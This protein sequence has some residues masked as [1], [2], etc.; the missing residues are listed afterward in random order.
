MYPNVFFLYTGYSSDSDQAI[1]H[2]CAGSEHLSRMDILATPRMS[3]HKL[4]NAALL[5][6]R[7]D[8]E[9]SKERSSVPEKES[10][11]KNQT[12]Q[13]KLKDPR[14]NRT[15]KKVETEFEKEGSLIYE[16]SSE[17]SLCDLANKSSSLKSIEMKDS[18]ESEPLDLKDYKATESDMS[19]DSLECL[20]IEPSKYEARKKKKKKPPRSEETRSQADKKSKPS[21]ASIVPPLVFPSDLYDWSSSDLSDTKCNAEQQNELSGNTKSETSN[22]NLEALSQNELLRVMKESSQEIVQNI[23]SSAIK[24]CE[25]GIPTGTL[26]GPYSGKIT[27]GFSC[28]SLNNDSLYSKDENIEEV[29]SEKTTINLTDI[30]HAKST[31]FSAISKR[32]VISM[33][34][35]TEHIAQEPGTVKNAQCSN[36]VK[37]GPTCTPRS[38][39]T[40]P[41]ESNFNKDIVSSKEHLDRTTEQHAMGEKDINSRKHNDFPVKL[42]D[43]HDN[44][45]KQI[46]HSMSRAL[47]MKSKLVTPSGSHVLVSPS[48]S[49][50]LVSS[51]VAASRSHVMVTHDSCTHASEQYSIHKDLM[52]RNPA[53]LEKPIA[54]Q[55]ELPSSLQQ[56]SA[57]DGKEI[58]LG[59]QKDLL[60]N[61]VLSSSANV[62]DQDTLIEEFCKKLPYSSKEISSKINSSS[63]QIP[64]SGYCFFVIGPDENV[65]QKQNK[66][67]PESAD[68]K[69]GAMHAVESVQRRRKTSLY[70]RSLSHQNE[71]KKWQTTTDMIAKV[72]HRSLSVEG[73]SKAARASKCASCPVLS[74]VGIFHLLR[75]LQSRQNKNLLKRFCKRSQTLRNNC[76]KVVT[77]LLHSRKYVL[78]GNLH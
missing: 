20:D 43:S 37:Q 35:G 19:V 25:R 3:R 72:H 36:E 76:E 44:I 31:S 60:G 73:K 64:T 24:K 14:K 59:S 10:K 32:E 7:K 75:V 17:S 78:E 67:N 9:A 69:D 65:E 61:D 1:R 45:T 47:N 51:D 53:R 16:G 38:T 11:A 12:I 18:E 34:S 6:N 63:D 29:C 33:A 55:I 77:H 8:R 70:R 26:L 62:D 50:A 23:M 49:Q 52:S 46:I 66:I 68:K 21:K 15:V 4:K 40:S 30:S 22:L 74:E 13:L 39:Q 27:G 48:R 57:Q 54:F 56:Y 5:R 28:E 41:V 58:S 2:P 42:Y 71:R